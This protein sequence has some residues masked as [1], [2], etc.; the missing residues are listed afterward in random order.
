MLKSLYSWIHKRFSR[1]EERS[2]YSGGYWQDKV[3]EA[4]LRL[5]DVSRGKILEVG[6]GEGLFLAK[7]AKENQYLNIVGVDVWRGILLKARR[8]LQSENIENVKLSNADAS[9]LPFKDKS[10]DFVVCINVFFNLPSE[11]VV[12]ASLKEIT[13]VCKT[14]GK[15]IFDIR[16]SLNPLLFLKYK[17]ARY[18]D[19]TVINLPLKTYRLKRI[20]AYLGNCGLEITQKIHI[21]FPNNALAPIIVMETTKIDPARALQTDE[22]T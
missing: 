2:E 17:F 8:R 4:A 15:I 13:R 14:G 21:G 19:V 16:N 11:E 7:L 1:A 3:R 22:R 5:C 12:F 18:Y 20:T 9:V 10:F 6:C